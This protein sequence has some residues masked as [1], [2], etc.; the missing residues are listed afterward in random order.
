MADKQYFVKVT[1][2]WGKQDGD[3]QSAESTGGQSW[4]N[5]TYDQSVMVQNGVVIPGVKYMLD[6]AG[7]MGLEM[8]DDA[9]IPETLANV[10]NKNIK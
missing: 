2:E 8:V 3:K 7:D 10:K 1:V 5:L 6:L 4:G 9:S